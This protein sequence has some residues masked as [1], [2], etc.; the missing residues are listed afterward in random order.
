MKYLKKNDLGRIMFRNC[1]PF[2]RNIR[3]RRLVL[4]NIKAVFLKIIK[5]ICYII[6]TFIYYALKFIIIYNI[7]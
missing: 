6:C 5:F 3:I 4:L 2:N 7:F 1:N